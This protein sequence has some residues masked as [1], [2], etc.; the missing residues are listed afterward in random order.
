MI[1]K[2]DAWGIVLAGYWNRMIFTPEW[3]GAHL[4]HQ[5]E[6]ETQI[7]LLPNFPVIYRHDEVVLEASDVRLIFR[8]R[9]NTNRSLEAAERMA[10]T[11]LEDMPYTPLIGVGINFSFVERNPPQSMLEL[12]NLGDGR[13]I[14]RAGWETPETKVTRK[15]TGQRGTM[16]LLLGQ[17]ADGV[18][19]D[20]NFHTDTP[21]T[22]V[23]A[24]ETARQAVAGRVVQLRDAALG[25]SRDIYNL[26]LEE[27]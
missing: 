21:G 25:F 11:V 9:F 14:A 8:P 10:V 26:Q 20:F 23:A 18:G 1:S 7:A 19:I 12:F 16:Q 15:L 4:F 5:E 17:D 27:G 24:N 13:S 2:Q 3:V 6:V 22:T